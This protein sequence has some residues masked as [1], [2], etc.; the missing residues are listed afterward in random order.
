M[1]DEPEVQMLQGREAGEHRDNSGEASTANLIAT[2]R[3]KV[4]VQ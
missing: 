2:S 3:W 4:D 1:R